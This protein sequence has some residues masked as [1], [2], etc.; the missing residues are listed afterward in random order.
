MEELLRVAAAQ[1]V[2]AP[3]ARPSMQ[4]SA[5]TRHHPSGNFIIYRRPS[6]SEDLPSYAAVL[7]LP[8][9]PEAFS[10]RRTATRSMARLPR[11]GID[12]TGLVVARV[13]GSVEVKL[14]WRSGIQRPREPEDVIEMVRRESRVVMPELEAAWLPRYA[15][16]VD[17]S[18]QRKRVQKRGTVRSRWNQILLRQITEEGRQVSK[19]L[20]DHAIRQ[21][22]G[23]ES[24]SIDGQLAS[25]LRVAQ[26]AERRLP[27]AWLDQLGMQRES[28]GPDWQD[29]A[30]VGA[31][32]DRGHW[33]RAPCEHGRPHSDGLRRRIV[34]LRI[35]DLAALFDSAGLQPTFLL[36]K[37]STRSSPRW[38]LPL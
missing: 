24:S 33:L 30:S 28:L 16:E 32:S 36:V 29:L 17:G 1:I 19:A 25:A 15:Q 2:K 38:V 23:S 26:K 34:E 20:E 18:W 11:M 12:P 37:E 6:P 7:Q 27:T 14:V 5:K 35:D 22:A 4:R 9:V 3:P 10:D 31:I 8:P 13:I 21:C